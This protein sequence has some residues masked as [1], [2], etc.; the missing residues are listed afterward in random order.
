MEISRA[1]LD[2]VAHLAR[3]QFDDAEAEKMMADMTEIVT[4]VEKLRE[5]YTE[6]VLPLVSMSE[7][8]ND[9]R[10]DAPQV[11]LTRDE[12]LSR[13]PKHDAQYFHVPKVIE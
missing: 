3:L 8:V 6:G 13:A 11:T 9:W 1:T 2:K 4:W 7:E 5:V 12:A 10:E